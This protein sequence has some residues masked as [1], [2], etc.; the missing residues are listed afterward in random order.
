MVI[1]SS[2]VALWSLSVAASVCTGYFVGVIAP[3]QYRKIVKSHKD[4]I[5]MTRMNDLY[6][7]FPS[8][9]K[10][11]RRRK[12]GKTSARAFMWAR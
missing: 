1:L 6:K 3:N 7:K 12:G 4:H 11:L 10:I 8:E 5:R 9:L 2:S